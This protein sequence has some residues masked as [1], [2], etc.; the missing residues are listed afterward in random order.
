MKNIYLNWL[1]VKPGSVT[2]FGLLNDKDDQ[3]KFYFDKN[4]FIK[5]KL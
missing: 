2:P 4:F 5:K 3:V 1:G